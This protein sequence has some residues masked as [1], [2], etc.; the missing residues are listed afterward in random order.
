M[1]GKM[2]RKKFIKKVSNALL[3][4]IPIY[5]V[6]SCSSSDDED[7]MAP[8]DDDDM[9]PSPDCLVN[10]TLSSIGSNHG[11]SLVVSKEDV[12]AGV[13]KEY[14]IQ[15]SSDHSHAITV[16]AANFSTLKT[17]SKVVVTSTSGGGHTHSV[18]ISCA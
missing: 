17:S 11:H 7:G 5:S 13:D 16:L 14:S 4:C 1:N 10:G 6:M 12:D 8:G 15:G 9:T 2:D 3:I 18:T